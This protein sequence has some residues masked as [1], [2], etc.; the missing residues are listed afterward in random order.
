MESHSTANIQPNYIK[1][2]KIIVLNKYILISKVTEEETTSSGI[3]LSTQ[4]SNEVRYK[5]ATVVSV[6]ALVTHNLLKEG[7]KILFDRVAGHIIR[8]DNVPYHIIQE[9]DVVVCLPDS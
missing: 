5:K 3:P 2:N 8:I 7:D 9:K 4:D 6:G 1:K